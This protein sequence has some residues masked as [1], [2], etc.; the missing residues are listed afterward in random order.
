M[1]QILE[2][3]RRFRRQLAERSFIEKLAILERLRERS[4]EIAASPL[5]A[6]AVAEA[7]RERTGQMNSRNSREFL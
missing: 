7:K 1:Q 4:L 2:S 3:K 5:R 6:Q